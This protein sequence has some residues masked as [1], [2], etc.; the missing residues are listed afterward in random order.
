MDIRHTDRNK[1]N[2]KENEVV[3]KGDQILILK[4]FITG[5]HGRI[6]LL[7]F[8]RSTDPSLSTLFT[9]TTQSIRQRRLFAHDDEANTHKN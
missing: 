8:S 1:T 7:T 5:F 4:Q 6:R 2:D 9:K 3:G